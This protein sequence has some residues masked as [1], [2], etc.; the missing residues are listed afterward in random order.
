MPKRKYVSNIETLKSQAEK[1][2]KTS[3]DPIY[4][5]RV[6]VVNSVLHGMFPSEVSKI[7][8]KSISTITSWVKKADEHGFES[9]IPGTHTGR[10]RKLQP[11]ELEELKSILINKP[12]NYGF[13]VWDGP[14]MSELIKQKYNKSISIRQCQRIF[15]ELGF[16]LIRPRTMPTKGENNEEERE[17]HKKKWL[18]LGKKVK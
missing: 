7:F 10:P 12:E 6:E 11:D 13:R 4:K 17:E 15:H 9:I 14:S 2:I 8:H 3:K 16:S 1:I 5:H 18:R